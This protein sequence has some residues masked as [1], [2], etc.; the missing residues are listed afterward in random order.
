[1]SNAIELPTPV[2]MPVSGVSY[3]Q[4]VVRS[5]EEGH[6]VILK[7]DR[8]NEFDANAVACYTLQGEHFGYVPKA[9]A[10][11]L[12]KD[13]CERWGGHVTEL[14]IHDTWGVRIKVTHSNVRD[15]PVQPKHTSF[16][17]AQ[18][19]AELPETVPSEEASG[20]Q[21]FSRSGRLLGV[22]QEQE[23]GSKV[24]RVIDTAGKSRIYPAAAV[25]VREA[26][27]Q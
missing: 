24:V 16:I 5:L 8:D 26:D 10:E 9:I 25:V 27:S 19:P 22:G 18:P 2:T 23:E 4:G 20:P 11:R 6:R 7:R 1:M 12:V 17:A 15:Y 3:R 21:V 13:G 14:L